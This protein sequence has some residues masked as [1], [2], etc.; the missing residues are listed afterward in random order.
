MSQGQVEEHADFSEGSMAA[1]G[2]FNVAVSHRFGRF[3]LNSD[4]LR[5]AIKTAM[6]Q[7]DRFC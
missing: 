1:I 5:G 3:R 6:A 7:I 2:L 4:A